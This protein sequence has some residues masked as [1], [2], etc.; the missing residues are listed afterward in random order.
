M[1][2]PLRYL[3]TQYPTSVVRDVLA[4]SAMRERCVVVFASAHASAHEFAQGAE[5]RV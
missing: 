3:P 2:T 4:L 5:M 1:L